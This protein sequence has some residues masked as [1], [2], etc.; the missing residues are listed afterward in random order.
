M[1]WGCMG[2]S[3]T[4]NEVRLQCIKLSGADQR[5]EWRLQTLLGASPWQ[6]AYPQRAGRKYCQTEGQ[7]QSMQRLPQ[8]PFAFPLAMQRPRALLALERPVQALEGGAAG[9]RSPPLGSMT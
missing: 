9:R 1:G 8:S 6:P 2:R 7:A 5:R 3:D 4:E